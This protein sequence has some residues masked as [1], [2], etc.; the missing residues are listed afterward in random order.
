MSNTPDPRTHAYR[1]DLAAKS[2]RDMVTA[3]HYVDP[4]IRQC[5]RGVVPLLAAPTPTARQVSEIRYGEFLDVFELPG[6]NKGY[7]WVQNRSDHY[8]GYLPEPDVLSE[9]IA[10]L[11][12]RISALRTFVYTEPDIKSPVTDELTLGSYVKL[13]PPEKDM[14]RLASGGYVFT[15]H[16]APANEVVVEDY[17]F[18]AGRLLNVPYLWGGRTPRGIDCSGLVQLALEMADIECPRDSDQQREAFGKPLPT[19]W[20]D[21]P[22]RRGDIVFFDP[23]HVGIMTGPEHLVHANGHYMQVTV[24]PIF[25]VVMRGLEIT[26]AGRPEI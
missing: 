20:R 8:V 5:V 19:H 14:R 6:G 26:A 2:L 11:S 4:V 22:W 1:P 16:I 18:T 25:D 23:N 3:A 21:M 24:E 12:N 13:G 7:A 15:K 17:V 9:H 10:D